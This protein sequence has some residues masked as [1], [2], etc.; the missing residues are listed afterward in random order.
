MEAMYVVFS[1]TTGEKPDFKAFEQRLRASTYAKERIAG[2]ADTAD[3]YEI[4]GASDAR[5]AKAGLETGHGR[6]VEA[7]GR[8]AT[9]DEE[10]EW[11]LNHTL[12]D[13]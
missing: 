2:G 13:R 12:E 4:E 9:P 1:L 8:R 3:V 10:F 5:A 7:H 6:F 11:F